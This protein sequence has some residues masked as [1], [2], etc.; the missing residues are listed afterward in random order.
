MSGYEDDLPYNHAADTVG[1]ESDSIGGAA[2]DRLPLPVVVDV[3]NLVLGGGRFLPVEQLVVAGV[4][5]GHLVL[6]LP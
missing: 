3:G 1:S 4:E 6:R 2:V 5:R